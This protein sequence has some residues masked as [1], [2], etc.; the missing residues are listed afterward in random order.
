MFRF[1]TMGQARDKKLPYHYIMTGDFPVADDILID[2]I[3][4]WSD[5]VEMKIYS[6]PGFLYFETKEDRL[7]FRLRWC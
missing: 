2:R 4:A 6:T 7:N 3:A 1:I 5:E